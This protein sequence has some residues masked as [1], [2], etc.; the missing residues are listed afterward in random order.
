M[1]QPGRSDLDKLLDQARA[2][3]DGGDRQTANALADQMLAADRAAPD[4]GDRLGLPPGQGEIRR[5]T[6]L[7]TDLV[8]STELSTRIDP[9]TYWVIVGHYRSEVER[10]V[11]RHGGHIASTKGD[12]ILAV[13]GHPVAHEKD[14]HRGIRTGIDITRSVADLN[15]RARRQFGVSVGVRVGIHHGRVFLDTEQDDVYGFAANLSARICGLATPG[16][17]AVSAAIRR[18]VGTAFEL[19]PLPPRPVKGVPDP[20]EHFRVIAEADTWHGSRGPLVGRDREVSLVEHAWQQALSVDSTAAAIAFAGEA[21]I[22][23]TRLVTVAA[24]LADQ[25][26]V[27]VLEMLGSPFHDNVGLHPIRRLI[28]RRCEITDSAHPAERLRMLTDELRSHGLDPAIMV[29]L[30]APVLDIAA[31]A[32]YHPVEADARMLADRIGAAVRDY[33]TAC[34]G[35]GPGLIVVEDMH[36]F[37]PASIEAIRLLLADPP[38]RTLVV[39]TTRDAARLPKTADVQVCSVTPLTDDETDEFIDAL[40][41]TLTSAARGAVRRRCDGVPL[42]IEEVVDKLK[43]LAVDPDPAQVPDNLYEALLSRLPAGDAA[44]TVVQAAATIGNQV[45]GELLRA[46]L[47]GGD[48]DLQTT[49][50]ELCAAKVLTPAGEERWRFRHELLREVA[51]ELA[52]PSVQRSLHGRVADAMISL[53][54]DGQPDWPVIATHFRAAH[55]FGEAATAYHQ[56]SAAARARGALDEARSHLSSALDQVVQQPGSARRDRHELRLRLRRGFLASAALGANNS[57]T[58]DD[59][60]R[61]LELGG[62]DLS[63]D[64]LFATLMALFTHFISRGDLRRAE[65]VVHTLRVAVDHGRQWWLAE[66]IGGLGILAWNHGEF[67]TARDLLTQSV[68][69]MAAREHRD[70][71]SVWYMPFDSVVSTYAQFATVHWILGDSAARDTALAD[72]RRRA[73]AL[74]FPQGPFSASFVDFIECL[75]ALDAGDRSAAAH[76]AKAMTER[77]RRHGF[78]ASAAAGLALQQSARAVGLIQTHPVDTAAV[79][80]ALPAVLQ[81]LSLCRA[82]EVKVWLLPSHAMAARLMIA[83]GEFEEA[84]QCLDAGLALSGET[85]LNY[86]DAELL[87]LRAQTNQD[88]DTR[89]TDLTAALNVARKQHATIFELRIVRDLLAIGDD[90][91][92]EMLTEVVGRFPAGSSWPELAAARA[93]MAE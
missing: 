71:E 32:G 16:T 34:L 67:E 57:D 28:E 11:A 68:Q 61:C 74:G 40:L 84:R 30:L 20:V 50:D 2:A 14:A 65:Q 93:S 53:T 51:A 45:D 7:F 37:D 31:Q 63:N 5:L 13:F 89:R 90:S 42:Y 86:Y 80:A 75:M 6:I 62:S 47:D 58:A 26:G 81:W 79:K 10:I 87:R 92:R 43:N 69:L 85:R 8:D 49:V 83:I 91:A 23:K 88:P 29:P 52:P 1:R 72:A 25:S 36:W 59:F 78:D 9:E 82:V 56:A 70:T 17:V 15:E 21:G 76:W 73:G 19:E 33:L 18:L 24:D 44:I 3:I 22:G 41:P 77:S 38:P 54:A 55:R 46:V 35:G 4:S 64:D 48:A 66:N 27:P 60:E 12:G 39:M